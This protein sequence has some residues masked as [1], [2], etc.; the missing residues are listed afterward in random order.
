MLSIETR[1]KRAERLMKGGMGVVDACRKMKIGTKTYYSHRPAKA[2]AK[3]RQR[4]KPTYDAVVLPS[5]VDER[6]T[7]TPK[8]LA[9]F[10]RE[11]HR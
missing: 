7:M 6:I 1:I 3:P 4:T 2:P 8:Q 5:E 9:Q 10:V 11:F